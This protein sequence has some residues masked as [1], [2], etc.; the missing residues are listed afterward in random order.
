MIDL[1]GY[2]N[3]LKE[4]K[5]A[6]VLEMERGLL[7][8]ATDTTSQLRNDSIDNGINFDGIEGAKVDYSDTKVPS[9]FFY[10]KVRNEAGRKF[11]KANKYASYYQ[12]RQSQGLRNAFVN[13]SYTGKFWAALNPGIATR[14]GSLVS[15]EVSITDGIV[16]QY[17]GYLA[18][19]YGTFYVPTTRMQ[20]EASLVLLDQLERRSKQYL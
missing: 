15:V 11:I 12:I 4:F 19:R 1:T 5:T 13:L 3:R 6:I 16:R 10:N 2:I 18:D 8:T 14:V 7:A 9:F 17:A 20:Q